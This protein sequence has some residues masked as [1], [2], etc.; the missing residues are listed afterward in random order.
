MLDELLDLVDENNQVIGT[1]LR[2]VAR[3]ENRLGSTRA[4][5]FLLKNRS[6]KFWIPQR[7]SNKSAC[8]GYLDGSAVGA[9]GAG[10]TYEQAMIREVEEELNFDATDM[11]YRK[12]GSLTPTTGS[13]AFIEIFELEVADEYEINYNQDD[14]SEFYWLSADEIIEKFEQGV[15]MRSTLASI[16]QTFYQEV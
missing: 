9:V 7:N 4:V 1:I 11:P 3:A 15:L 8:P 10:E 2:S 13:L 5:W 14:F 16:M 12:I 6:N